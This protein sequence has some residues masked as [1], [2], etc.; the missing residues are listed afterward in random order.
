V[1]TSN[2][3]PKDNIFPVILALTSDSESF[4]LPYL[5]RCTTDLVCDYEL[6]TNFSTMI[7]CD[8]TLDDQSYDTALSSPISGPTSSWI[9]GNRKLSTELERILK[10]TWF[11]SG[12]L[13]KGQDCRED[14]L[15]AGLGLMTGFEPL[16][17]VVKGDQLNAI[18]PTS[19]SVYNFIWL[20]PIRPFAVLFVA[21]ILGDLG[22]IW[23]THC[24]Q[25][26]RLAAGISHRSRMNASKQLMS[27]IRIPCSVEAPWLSRGLYYACWWTSNQKIA[28]Q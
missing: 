6:P 19:G 17:R 5:I 16:F 14:R 23:S 10:M 3:N 18:F 24:V 13:S 21:L 11:C 28:A 15:P 1:H 2:C 12:D 4:L 9:L 20:S 8:D 25:T 26:P 27:H 22:R 7:D